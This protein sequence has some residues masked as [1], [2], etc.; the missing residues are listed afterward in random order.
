MQNTLKRSDFNLARQ[1]IIQL[2]KLEDDTILND[3]IKRIDS[4]INSEG[5]SDKNTVQDY[6]Y[7]R[8]INGLGPN[9]SKGLKEELA[10]YFLQLPSNMGLRAI[11]KGLPK[12][13]A[14]EVSDI[15]KNKTII[16]RQAV[17]PLEVDNN[18]ISLAKE[19]LRGIKRHLR[20]L[21]ERIN[22]LGS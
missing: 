18:R 5:L 4:A 15:V 12:A 10:N 22:P 20:S 11:K 8:I 21:N 14:E 3:T 17:Q 19:H 2:Q 9:L 1:A 16:L 6:M 13:A 7:N